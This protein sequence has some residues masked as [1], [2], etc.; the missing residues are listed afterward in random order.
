MS[1]DIYSKSGLSLPYLI[2]TDIERWLEDGNKE[3]LK[4]IRK[5]AV[6]GT[7]ANNFI[8]SLSNNY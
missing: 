7:E 1:Y 4:Y 5:W 6:L 3:R 8:N 2:D